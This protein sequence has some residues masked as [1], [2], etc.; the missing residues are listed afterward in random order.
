MVAYVTETKIRILTANR[1]YGTF[2][3]VLIYVGNNDFCTSFYLSCH[4]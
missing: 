4:L 3:L 1:L 2:E